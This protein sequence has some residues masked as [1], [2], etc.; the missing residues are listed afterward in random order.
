LLAGSA[1]CGSEPDGPDNKELP[2][3]LGIGDAHRTMVVFH[4]GVALL[5][6]VT[7]PA[8]A[9]GAALLEARFARSLLAPRRTQ[10]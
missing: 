2:E 7:L 6:V 3:L 9:R 10:R 8:V 1:A 5:C 4:A